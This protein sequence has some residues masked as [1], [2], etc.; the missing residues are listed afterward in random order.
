MWR[1]R[2]RSNWSRK[3]ITFHCNN[4]ARIPATTSSDKGDARSTP[5]ISAPIVA[6]N[7]STFT[8]P[9]PRA[10]APQPVEVR[11]GLFYDS[12]LGE[13]DV[14]SARRQ[15]RPFSRGLRTRTPGLAAAGSWEPSIS[16]V[17]MLLRERLPEG[18]ADSD[19]LDLGGPRLAARK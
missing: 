1:S 3:K 15:R 17:A 7:G 4:A 16:S 13:D 14:V 9:K 18:A 11:R 10:T 8:R 5:P 12:T 19:P 6:V 2:S